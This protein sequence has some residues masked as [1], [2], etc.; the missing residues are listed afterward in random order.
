MRTK[1]L[2]SEQLTVILPMI[3]KKKGNYQKVMYS[4]GEKNDA[5]PGRGDLTK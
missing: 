5:L 1:N 2:D 3:S 4:I